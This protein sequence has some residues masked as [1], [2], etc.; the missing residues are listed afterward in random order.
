MS[1][2]GATFKG[3]NEFFFF[4]YLVPRAILY[5]QLTARFATVNVPEPGWT[6]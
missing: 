6:K 5:H 4:F 2:T 3:V 1:Y